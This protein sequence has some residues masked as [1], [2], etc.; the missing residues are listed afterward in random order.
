M[1][2]S[3]STLFQNFSCPFVNSSLSAFLH[4]CFFVICIF[5]I[6]RINK[7]T[8]NAVLRLA[9]SAQH[10]CFISVVYSFLFLNCNLYHN[11]YPFPGNGYLFPIFSVIQIR[12]HSYSYI[13]ICIDTHMVD[14]VGLL[15]CQSCYVISRS[16][17]ECMRISIPFFLC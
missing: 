10:S 6:F 15:K 4:L 9:S 2:T 5:Q 13:D 17:L 14:V 16:F 7:I 8:Q 3:L 1:M 11:V 12:Y